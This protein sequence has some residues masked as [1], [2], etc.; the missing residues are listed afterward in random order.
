MTILNDIHQVLFNAILLFSLAIAVWATVMAARN[1][2][3]SGQFWGA[4]SILTLLSF[5]TLSVGVILWL[6]GFRLPRV[7]TY[8]IYMAW[9]VIIIP[10]MFTQLRGRDD[11]SAALAFAMLS[12]FNFFVGLSMLSRG[13]IGPWQLG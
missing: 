4:I 5:I 3:I 9:M 1:R 11:A 8:F 10:G 7:N 2:S 13:L 6:T 12:V